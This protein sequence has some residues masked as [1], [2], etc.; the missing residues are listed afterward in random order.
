MPIESNKFWRITLRCYSKNIKNKVRQATD[1][2]TNEK[3]HREEKL[4]AI[5][6][7]LKKENENSAEII[8]LLQIK[9]LQDAVKEI[10]KRINID[11]T[12]INLDN[13]VK[14]YQEARK[15]I[16][17]EGYSFDIETDKKTIDELSNQLS[18]LLNPD[19]QDTRKERKIKE[20]H[21]RLGRAAWF[22]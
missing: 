8:R 14:F 5:Q 3:A 1:V 10:D 18:D 20:L 21:Y 2:L 12:I 13:D 9:L 11:D 15:N 7:D 17:K 16:S 6:A 22:R 19:N 4:K